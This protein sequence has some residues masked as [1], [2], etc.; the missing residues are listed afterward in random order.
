MQVSTAVRSVQ[1]S[2]SEEGFPKYLN[3]CTS[4]FLYLRQR[5]SWLATDEDTFVVEYNHRTVKTYFEQT[6]WPWLYGQVTIPVMAQHV[7]LLTCIQTLRQ[8]DRKGLKGRWQ[9]LASKTHTLEP[10]VAEPG[11]LLYALEFL[12]AHAAAYELASGSSTF[13]LLH[14]K[15]PEGFIACHKSEAGE[16]SG[17]VYRMCTDG[18]RSFCKFGY[19]V[20]GDA[21]DPLTLVELMAYQGATLF[22]KDYLTHED[23]NHIV[24]SSAEAI[25]LGEN[26]FTNVPHVSKGKERKR[27]TKVPVARMTQRSARSTQKPAQSTQT[28]ARSTQTS[29]RLPAGPG[30]LELTG[31]EMTRR[32][33]LRTILIAKLNE[34]GPVDRYLDAARLAISTCHRLEECD[35]MAALFC[36]NEAQPNLLQAGLSVTRPGRLQFQPYSHAIQTFDQVSQK[37]KSEATAIGPFWAIG[38]AMWTNPRFLYH[39]GQEIIDMFLKRGHNLHDIDGPYGTIWHSFIT[40][41]FLNWSN[42][43]FL[44][45]NFEFLGRNDADPC[46]SG[47]YGNALEFLWR[48][49]HSPRTIQHIRYHGWEEDENDTLPAY[50]L[51]LLRHLLDL[52]V[53]NN[54]RDPNGKVPSVDDMRRQAKNTPEGT[55]P[56]K[57][58]QHQYDFRAANGREPSE[59]ELSCLVEIDPGDPAGS[60]KAALVVSFHHYYGGNFV[61]AALAEK[62]LSMSDKAFHHFIHDW[63][64]PEEWNYHG[65]EARAL[66]AVSSAAARDKVSV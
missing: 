48:V 61:D 40:G 37:A 9:E 47:V 38:I 14:G 17:H 30:P 28:S 34:E 5:G 51:E 58:L 19:Y 39:G 63:H 54:V 1:G 64:D 22:V 33:T 31:R 3:K 11:M 59:D 60:Q 46:L 53:P 32:A 57:R 66:C 56:M 15:V 16:Y 2:V 24:R 18:G 21:S 42:G 4:C 25:P 49:L 43:P 55:A 23:S 52:D 10:P 7:W 62:L 12:A 26:M 35:I 50:A 6:A 29:G 65:Q 36:G 8:Q 27:V 20:P 41:M 13:A 45:Q 44:P